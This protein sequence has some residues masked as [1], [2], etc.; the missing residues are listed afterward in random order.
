VNISQR[1]DCALQ[2][3]GLA[4]RARVSLLVMT[5]VSGSALISFGAAA[6]ASAKTP[7]SSLVPAKIR[8]T[9]NLT[10]LVNSPYTPM[11]YQ[12]TAG[13]PIVGFDIDVARAIAK[14]LALKLVVTN[15]PNFAELTPAVQTGRTDIVD[16]SMLDLTSRHASLHFVDDFVTGTQFMGLAAKTAKFTTN[17]ALCG[18]TVVVQSGTSYA[19]QIAKLSKSICPA[20]KPIATISVTSPP[21]QQTQVQ[22][23][24]A[25]AL[26][27]GP[28]INGALDLSQPNKW[29]VIGKTF[30]VLDYGIVFNK[31]NTQLGVALKAALNALI[32]NGTY[33]KILVKWHLSG[34]GVTAATVD[35]G[36]S[37]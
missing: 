2:G 22:I 27:Q 13:G 21:E 12:A 20:T 9:G 33:N 37:A 18:K 23:G 24:R 11:E 28:E 10:D 36:G 30:N 6:S 16:S 19:A 35:K 1:K 31:S 7:L 25:I 15:T 34:D 4:R 32:K 5:V 26:A 29:H 8:A 17:A 3:F 14:E